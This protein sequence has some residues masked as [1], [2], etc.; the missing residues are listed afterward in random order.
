[1]TA[2]RFGTSGIASRPVESTTAGLSAAPGMG[3]MTGTDPVARMTCSL[4]SVSPFTLTL[5][6]PSNVP[7]P[8]MTVTPAFFSAAPT[9]ATRPFTTSS[10][11]AC[12]RAQS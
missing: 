6:G 1:M 7:W 3:G 12:M 8:V 9:P 11:Q 10:F 2:S 4:M 5:P